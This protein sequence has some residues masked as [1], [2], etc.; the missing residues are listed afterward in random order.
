MKSCVKT[1]LSELVKFKHITA[2]IHIF[3]GFAEAAKKGLGLILILNQGP[4]C[5]SQTWQ[6]SRIILHHPDPFKDNHHNFDH[7]HHHFDH[8]HPF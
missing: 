1:V 7:H 3:E 2:E 8:S 6:F 4:F 5:V